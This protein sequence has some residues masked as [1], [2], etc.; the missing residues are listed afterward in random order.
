MNAIDINQSRSPAFGVWSGWEWKC[1]ELWDP[2]SRSR[3]GL[4]RLPKSLL[5]AS[6]IIATD[7]VREASRSLAL[8]HVQ[9]VPP[10]LLEL[11]RDIHICAIFTLPR[12]FALKD[13]G[14][15]LPVIQ[16]VKNVHWIDSG[17]KMTGAGL[18]L[19]ADKKVIKIW[20]GIAL[21]ICAFL[22]YQRK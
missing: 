6:T 10:M 14:Y 20:T 19:S 12:N 7:G 5:S 8:L 9:M 17:A 21:V 16:A 18:V 4:L 11:L 15:E 13:L 3:V 1:R 22:S 2:R